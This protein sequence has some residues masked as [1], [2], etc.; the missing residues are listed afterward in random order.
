MCCYVIAHTLLYIVLV[1]MQVAELLLKHGAV[2]NIGCRDEGNSACNMAAMEG[3]IEM[4]DLLKKSGCDIN[5]GN[6]IGIT[7][8]GSGQSIVVR[9]EHNIKCKYYSS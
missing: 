7:A 2:I 8:V 5:R 9:A 4:L 6:T 3:H 1:V